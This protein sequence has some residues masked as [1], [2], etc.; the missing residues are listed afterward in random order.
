[1]IF[2]KSFFLIA[3]V[4]A[5]YTEAHSNAQASPHSAAAADSTAINGV[6]SS[7]RRQILQ[8]KEQLLVA[9]K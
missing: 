5:C 3:V 8:K 1:L 4:L 6:S 2:R 7:K 9:V